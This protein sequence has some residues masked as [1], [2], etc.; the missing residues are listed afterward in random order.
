MSS[1]LPTRVL[2]MLELLRARS[3]DQLSGLLSKRPSGARRLRMRQ[4]STPENVDAIWSHLEA[5][6]VPASVR[7]QIGDTTSR[8]AAETQIHTV[9]P[10]YGIMSLAAF[11]ALG[12]KHKLDVIGQAEVAQA[13]G[14]EYHII[15]KNQA[16]LAGCKGKTLASDHADDRKFIDKVVAGGKFTLA[17]FTLVETKRP[18]QTLKKVTGGEA[19]CVAGG[20]AWTR[21]LRCYG[22][23]PPREHEEAELRAYEESSDTCACVCEA[24]RVECMSVP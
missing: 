19:E 12:P 23:P 5:A 20:C 4:D 24:D 22:T 16:D 3:P 18:V 17:D 1:L 11:L 2:D 15:S 10:H 9:D 8:E 14:R 21:P 7:G 6:G 13:G